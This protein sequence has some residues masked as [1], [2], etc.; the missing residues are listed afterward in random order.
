MPDEGKRAALI[1]E[2]ATEGE[3]DYL[4]SGGAKTEGLTPPADASADASASTSAAAEPGKEPAKEPA[5]QP[6]PAAGA[7]PGAQPATATPGADDEDGPEP[8]DPNATIPYQK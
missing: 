1:A 8:T 2:G 6:A 7:Q 3:A 5:K 4:L